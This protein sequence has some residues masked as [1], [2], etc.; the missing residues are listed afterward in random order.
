MN[1]VMTRRARAA[2]ALSMLATAAL[3]STV[4]AGAPAA[5]S[6]TPPYNV[7]GVHNVSLQDADFVNRNVAITWEE[8]GSG[9]PRVGIRTS[10]DRGSTFGPVSI[11]PAARQSAVDVCGGSELD[12]V[13]ARQ[14]APGNWVIERAVGSM[15]GGG[16]A[17]GDVV[18]GAGVSRFPDVACAGGRVFVS[19]F[20]REGSGDRL[21]V[22]HAL[23]SDGVFSAPVDLGLDDETFYGRSL[24]VAG[25]NDTAY[26]VYTRS[27]GRLRLKRWTIG[28][29]PG[30]AVTSHPALLIGPGT[31]D[32]SASDA[33]IAA[34]GDTVAVAWFRCDGIVAR[35]SNDRGKTWG[36]LRTV[37]EH[38][39]CGGDFGASQRSIAI[40]GDRIVIT[41]LAFGIESPGWVGIISTTNDFATLSDVTI[42]PVGHD[43]HLVGFVSVGGAARLAAAYD[44]GDRVRF[45]RQP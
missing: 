17:V 27:D 29:G 35:V 25:V 20:Q 38:V 15:A 2:V 33:V 39:A 37:L 4:A 43:E 36:P 14:V 28:G 32:D 34:A 40:R 6:W 44:P 16:F 3:A 7:R 9:A 21:K 42:A 31:P 10:V 22:A 11:F 41:Y 23:R 1:A 45:R 26:V 18:P 12:A 30:F 19:W 5:I 8:P 13:Y 24:A